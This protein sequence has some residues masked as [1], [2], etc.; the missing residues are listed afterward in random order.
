MRDGVEGSPIPLGERH[1]VRL[2]RGRPL[3]DHRIVKPLAHG[4]YLPGISST[5]WSALRTWVSWY[6]LASSQLKAAAHHPLA[7]LNPKTPRS[8]RATLEHGLRP[9]ATGR[10]RP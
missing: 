2:V 9:R 3:N 1:Q 7:V 4:C 6:G 5:A 10:R 8:P